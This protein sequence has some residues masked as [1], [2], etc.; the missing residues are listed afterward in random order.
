MK[1]KSFITACI[2]E[3]TIYLCVVYLGS[4]LF[5]MVLNGVCFFVLVLF[6]VLFFEVG[7][8]IIISSSNLFHWLTHTIIGRRGLF[9]HDTHFCFNQRAEILDC[10]SY[11]AKT[12]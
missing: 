9:L 3:S 7:L 1:N 4:F 6:L 12:G 8:C 2:Y 10:I 5:D 11:E